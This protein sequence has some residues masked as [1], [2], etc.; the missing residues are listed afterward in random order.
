MQRFFTLLLAS[1][2]LLIARP[3]SA[4]PSSDRSDRTTPLT[5]AEGVE[6]E[7]TRWAWPI[8]FEQSITTN[9]FRKGSQLSHS[10]SYVWW[11][12]TSPS[13][14]IRDD[15]TVRVLASFSYQVNKSTEEEFNRGGYYGR[16]FVFDDMRADL[17]YR[18]PWE[19]GGV[20]LK[21]SFQLRIPTSE[22]SRTLQRIISPGVEVGAAK[23]F[24]QVLAGL[25]L[26][27][28]A[29]Y[30]GW[31][32]KSNVAIVRDAG[33]PCRVA[34]SEDTVTDNCLGGSSSPRHLTR[35][36]ADV[37]LRPIEKLSV[38]TTFA[39]YWIRAFGLQDAPIDTLTG[40]VVIGDG[41]ANKHWRTL[42]NLN[43]YIGYDITDYLAGTLSYDTWASHPDSDG[44]RESVIFNENTRILFT[45]DFSVER[46][47][48]TVRANRRSRAA[49]REA[50]KQV[51]SA[52]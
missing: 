28:T 30:W 26:T 29:R 4:E 7:Q 22:A 47:Y 17:I 39:A 20:K 14:D 21:S 31:F 33:F 16:Q 49:K 1:A 9:S 37:S 25:D 8:T 5:N 24:D 52:Q 46:L 12:D 50:A 23:T 34:G 51:A 35:L 10:P 43:F 2:F 3:A 15:L 18:L 44:G 41:S 36:L 48:T 6:L 42:S 13:Y 19:P 27:L 32:A 40:P 11:F 38:G 45:L